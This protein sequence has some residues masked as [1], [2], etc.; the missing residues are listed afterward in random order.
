M[1]TSVGGVGQ[2]EGEG[3]RYLGIRLA[4]EGGYRYGWIGLEVNDGNTLFLIHD[5]CVSGEVGEAVEL[6]LIHI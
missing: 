6:S 5:Y 1:G 2:F 4:V 3:K